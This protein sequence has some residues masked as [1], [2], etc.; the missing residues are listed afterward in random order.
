MSFQVVA[1][2]IREWFARYGRATGPV[3]PDGWFG[4]PY[5]SVLILEGIEYTTQ[6]LRLSFR[7]QRALHFEDRLSVT[8]LGRG[9][10]FDGCSRCVFYEAGSESSNR[11]LAE[12]RG[13]VVLLITP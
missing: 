4:R 3:F 6:H 13:G 10:M 8:D 9:L 7:C 2:D 5:D 1:D 12:H 11:L